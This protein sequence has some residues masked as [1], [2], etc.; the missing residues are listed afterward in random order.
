M[1]D[2]YHILVLGSVALTLASW[3]IGYDSNNYYSGI[4]YDNVFKKTIVS[5]SIEKERL[6]DQKNNKAVLGM[7]AEAVNANT[8]IGLPVDALMPELIGTSSPSQMTTTASSALV[9]D[10]ESGKILFSKDSDKVHAIA[11]ITKLFTAFVFLDFNPGWDKYYQIKASDRREGGKVYV[12]TG[13]KLSINDLFHLSLVASGNTE[14]LALVNATGLGE[15]L[16]VKKMNEKA[17]ELGLKNT[18]FKDPVGLNEGNVSTAREIAQF[19]KIALERTEISQTVRLSKWKFTTKGGRKAAV[20]TTDEMLG[21]K[22]ECNAKV[23]GGKTGF[24]NR[25]G[26]CFVGKFA[27]DKK[28]NLISVILGETSKRTRFSETEKLIGWAYDNY[29]WQ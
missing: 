15:E 12:W 20:T 28:Q 25:A 24:N 14:T 23:M 13:E 27:N 5:D 29:N 7:R 4:V 17:K 8:M 16:F 2:R 22:L 6:S 11:S 1:R 9:M 3:L 18:V 21:D 19:A 26:Y 10:E